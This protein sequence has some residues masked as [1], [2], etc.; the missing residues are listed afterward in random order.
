[1]SR[2]LLSDLVV[3]IPGITGSTLYVRGNPVWELSG[4]AVMGG[5]LSLGRNI[6]DLA[7]EDGFGDAFPASAG[8][9]EPDDGVEAL[10]LMRD[11]HVVPGL[12]SPIK[13]YSALVGFFSR[14]FTVTAGNI[15]EFPYDWRLSNAVS[16]RR[17]AAMALPALER[18]RAQTNNPDAKLVLV[19]HSMG[20]LVSRWFLEVCG[21]WEVT[22]WLITLGTPYQGAM[23]SVDALARGLSKGLGSLRKDLTELV[24][25]FPSMH[26][27]LPTYPCVDAGSGTLRTV[28]DGGLG[29]NSAMVTSA[30]EFHSRLAAAVD[31]RQ[32]R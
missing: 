12:W 7:L 3:V 11:L 13:G 16:G 15:I 20:G 28:T 10:G 27:L 8:S 30:A 29:L 5:V 4:R 26:E 1:V 19:A 21:G 23:N 24:S 14:R 31:G 25:S 32:E 22:R 9:G 2:P 6:D 18:W 17:L